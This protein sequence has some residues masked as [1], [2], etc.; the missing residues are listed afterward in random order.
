MAVLYHPAID[1]F[2]GS[3]RF[4]VALSPT[5][6]PIPDP[7][8]PDIKPEEEHKPYLVIPIGIHLT[9]ENGNRLTI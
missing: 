6:K 5:V 8:K 4:T 7:Y 1:E 9:D 3:D 2:R